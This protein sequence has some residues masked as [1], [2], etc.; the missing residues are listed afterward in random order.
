MDN[1]LPVVMS[2][3]STWLLCAL[4]VAGCAGGP[5]SPADTPM[6]LGG[7][8]TQDRTQADIDAVC[9]IVKVYNAPCVLMESFPEQF[10][11]RFP[12]APAC[13]QARARIVAVPHT[14]VGACLATA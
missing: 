13:E 12:S 5:S 7:S 14:M 8:F 6:Q 11:F 10:S 2:H 9:D 4:V 1:R 3:G